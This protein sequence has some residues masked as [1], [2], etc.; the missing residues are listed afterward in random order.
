MAIR[1]RI[2]V[3]PEHGKFSVYLDGELVGYWEEEHTA[4]VYLEGIITGISTERK[5]TEILRD[6]IQRVKSSME[7]LPWIFRSPREDAYIK[8]FDLAFDKEKRNAEQTL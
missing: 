3:A 7:A 1:D 2:K 4:D 6:V 8:E 5:T